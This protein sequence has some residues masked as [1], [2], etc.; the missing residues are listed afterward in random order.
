MSHTNSNTRGARVQ[1]TG[2]LFPKS[3]MRDRVMPSLAYANNSPDRPRS[4]HGKD[5]GDLPALRQPL[6][7][8]TRHAQEEVGDRAALALR[9]MQAGLHARPRRTP[10]Q[11]LPAADDPRSSYRLRHRLFA[12]RDRRTAQEEDQPQ[13]LAL[14]DHDLAAGL[15]EALQLPPTAPAGP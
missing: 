11:D 10:Q 9:V 2:A 6:A 14:D 3:V 5:A 4:A 8:A 15:R 13:H 12:R 1:Y 7:H